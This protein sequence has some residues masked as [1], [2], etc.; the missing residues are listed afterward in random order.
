VKALRLE[1][2]RENRLL[3][4]EQADI[5]RL[6]VSRKLNPKKRGALGQYLTPLPV[7]SF[8]ASL[9]GDALKSD[10]V[11]LDPGAGTGTLTASFI[12]EMRTRRVKPRSIQ[13]EC[14]ELEPIMA[15]YLKSTLEECRRTSESRGIHV[16]GV[17]TQTDFIKWG[18]EHLNMKG[19]LFEKPVPQFTHCI[20]NPPYKKI[21]NDSN[22]RTWL[23]QIG[24]E[25]SNLYSGF[26]AV[27]IKLLSSEG[28]LVAIVPRSF[29]NGPYFRPFRELLLDNMAIR[30][31]HVFKDR[32]KAFKD[33]AVLQENIIVHAVKGGE[34]R[35]VVI[36]S[37]SGADFDEMTQREVPFNKVVKPKDP[38]RFIHIATSD[39]D[40]LVVDRIIAFSNT[41]KDIGIEVCTGPVVDFRLRD[42]IRQT[43]EEGAC[44]LIYPRHFSGNYVEWPN[45]DGKKPNSI[46]E[47]EKSSRW[48]M[49]N[50]WYVVTRRFSSKE[51]RRRIVAALHTPARVPG[52]KIGF[53]NHLNVFHQGKN[54]LDPAVAKG[55]AIFLNSTLLDLYF[56]QFSGHTQVNAT[57]LRMLHYPDLAAL[58]RLGEHVIGVFPTQE[59]RDHILDEE[60]DDM[61]K[62]DNQ[63]PLSVQ[64][65]I[66]EALSTLKA[67]GLPKGQLNERSALTLLALVDLKSDTN[68]E[69]AGKPLMG[70]TPI[71]DYIRDHY[72]KQYAPNTRETIR[73]QTMH[74]FIDAGVAVS[75]PDQ[76]DRP[77][78]SP[79]WCYQ[80]T[81]DT[82]DL[83]RSF[84]SKSWE[85]NLAAYLKKRP[86]LVEQYAKERDMQ[87]IPL[88][89]N[90]DKELS[91]TP[92]RHS[93][94]IKDIITDFGP[95]YAPG[96]DVLYVG[97]TGFKMGHF[98][99]ETFKSLNLTFDN[100]GKFPDVV[101]H[102]GS[103]KWL[104]LIESVTSHGPV[105]AKRHA[106]LA[107]LFKDSS[108]G[109]IYVTAFP[110]RQT[111]AKYLGDISWETEVWVADAPSHLIH[112]NGERFLGP[113][114]ENG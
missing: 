37:S 64:R 73:R 57:D 51:E 75:N 109:I 33:D 30:H 59:E 96:A 86:P 24:I 6:E 60:L 89:I 26:L 25:T 8:M 94:L 99:E 90:G 78:N 45:L 55:L 22:H 101:L 104:L 112:F 66:K 95:R 103:K 76:P 114:R 110:D 20:M 61:T 28:E 58:R 54:G 41:L 65:R 98:D 21:R 82:L 47:S 23:R 62:Q 2:E 63:N 80:I 16:S 107:S 38:D 108:A 68:W 18:F 27:A 49:E 92:G 9:F 53:E 3:P 88:E 19:T 46:Y 35:S 83:I 84:G 44:P 10:I 50:G 43:A 40:Q 56:R 111:M 4:A 67:L 113:Y 11:L 36:S 71:M 42:D 7:A 106:E 91:L 52:Q 105:D 100:H 81:P 70:I 12:Q 31:L 69:K 74:Q 79:K 32:N 34:Q 87:M 48:L 17:V 5:Y 72:G 77:V 15:N 29:C 14:Y 97:D 93:Q 1:I 102:L 39:M 13:A 85:A